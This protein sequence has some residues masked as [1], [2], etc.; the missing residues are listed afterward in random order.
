MT[1]LGGGGSVTGSWDPQRSRLYLVPLEDAG[2][3]MFWLDRG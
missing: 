2:T 3:L 1:G